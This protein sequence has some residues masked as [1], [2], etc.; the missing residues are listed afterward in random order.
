[1]NEEKHPDSDPLHHVAKIRRKLQELAEH[2]RDDIPK[3]HEPKA[4]VLFE[5]TAEVLIGLQTAYEHYTT[6]AEPAMQR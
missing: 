4:K 2:C 6:Q 5:T 3:I 1:M